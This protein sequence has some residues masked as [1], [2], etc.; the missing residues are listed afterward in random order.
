MKMTMIAALLCLASGC[1]PARSFAP[2]PQLP[3]NSGRI[4]VEND[5]M[6]AVKVFA[7]SEGQVALYLGRVAAN[8]TRSFGIS[9]ESLGSFRLETRPMMEL[10]PSGRHYSEI[11]RVPTGSDITWRLLAS[12]T[13]T[14]PRVSLLAIGRCSVNLHC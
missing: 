1:A 14:S 10:G 11:V 2:A 4:L 3:P 7:V 5:G 13:S 6:L 9:P 8:A 12:P